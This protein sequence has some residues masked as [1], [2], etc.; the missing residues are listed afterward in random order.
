[1]KKGITLIAVLVVV[2]AV[3]SGGFAAANHYLITSSS[4][5]RNGAVSAADL[6]PAAHKALQGKKGDTGA[7]GPQGP[8]GAQGTPGLPGT[9]G[10]TG[11]QGAPGKD[12]KDAPTPQYAEGIVKVARGGNPATT[13]ATYS[14]SLG[15]PYGD[16][17]SGAFRFTCP[18]DKAPCNVSL[19]AASTD[20]SATVYPRI[21]IY[22]SDI[23][24]GQV[25]GQCEYGDGANNNNSYESA[26]GALTVGIGGTLDC[27]AGQVNPTNGIA[28]EIDVPAGYY[29]VWSTFS[30]K[31]S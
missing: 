3:T 7:T 10:A 31:Q 8:A 19:A 27:G 6:S 25:S 16:T 24:T 17:A 29:D 12:G 9:P 23:N 14:T 5:I 30:F 28:T 2:L 21:L 11:P 20:A 1:L 4:Q 15:S 18:A 26:N 13:W 22:K